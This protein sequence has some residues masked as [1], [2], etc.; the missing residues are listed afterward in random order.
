MGYIQSVGWYV[1]CDNLYTDVYI[2]FYSSTYAVYAS[3]DVYTTSYAIYAKIYV[4]YLKTM[5]IHLHVPMKISVYIWRCK[6]K[7]WDN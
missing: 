4:E 7:S 6:A 3:Y 5:F 2:F 1:E